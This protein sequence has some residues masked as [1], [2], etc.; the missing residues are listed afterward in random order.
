[1]LRKN[2]TEGRLGDFNNIYKYLKG[3]GK[4]SQQLD[5]SWQRGLATQKAKRILGCIKSTKLF[6]L[7]P[8]YIKL[9]TFKTGIL[10][11]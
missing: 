8:T 1:M 5:M 9:C 10:S 7:V 4:K 2:F 3:V 6:Y 11:I